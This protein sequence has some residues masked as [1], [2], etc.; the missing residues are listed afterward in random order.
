MYFFSMEKQLNGADDLRAEGEV[1]MGGVASD[2]GLGDSQLNWKFS[3][4]CFNLIEGSDNIVQT[5]DFKCSENGVYD[6]VDDNDYFEPISVMFVQDFARED[7]F[8]LAHDPNFAYHHVSVLQKRIMIFE[9][10][11]TPD[12]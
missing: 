1:E 12:Y 4:H 8:N 6:D 5:F 10:V 3:L 9:G 2:R 7:K 11:I